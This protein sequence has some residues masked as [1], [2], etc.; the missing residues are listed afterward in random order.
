MTVF[1]PRS[2]LP[3]F[4]LSLGTALLIVGCSSSA[5]TTNAP[6]L[7][8]RFPNH[9]TDE[10]RSRIVGASDTLRAY[11][12]KARVTV[13]SP[14]QSRTFNAVVR[15]RRADSLFMR[16]SLFGIEGGRLLLT[17]DSVFF[18]DT[19]KGVLRV[20]PA[21]AVQNLFPAPVSSANFFENMLGLIAPA[22]QTDWSL[23]A[24][25]TLYYVS[26]PNG[27]RRYAIDPTRWRVVRYEQRARNGTLIQRRRFSN[28][29][30]VEGIRLPAQLVFQRPAAN[31][32]AVVHYRSMTL[33]PSDLSFAL[34]VP[35]EVPRRSFARGQ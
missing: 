13:Q 24:D 26:S 34:N 4:A 17:R 27:C 9:T 1:S 2:L 20:G 22:P 14:N 30:T 32:R 23:Q 35:P 29:H 28:F 15:H 19:R 12:A 16:V 11:R 18:Y 21:K 3:L 7:P 6:N 10:I 25:S 31:L 33:N 5:R 8:T